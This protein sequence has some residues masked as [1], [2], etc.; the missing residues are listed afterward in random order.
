MVT[1]V[2]AV[3]LVLG[4]IP[5]IISALEHYE[6]FASPTISFIHWRRHLRRLIQELY[7]IQASYDQAIRLLLKPFADLADQI[8]M[9]E[10]PRSELWIEGD[11][12]D[13]LR[14]KL[15]L[16]YRPFTLTINEM[17]DILIEIALCLNISGS[18]Q[19]T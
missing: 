5:L 4:A 3:G 12:A 2:E 18:Q 14:D 10:D 13:S 19:V 16:V 15:G 17:S 1:G 7:T 8:K 11:I 6:D 9:M